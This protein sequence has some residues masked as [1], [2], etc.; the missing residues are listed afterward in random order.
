VRGLAEA[1]TPEAVA[2]IEALKTDRDREVRATAVKGIAARTSD[3][4]ERAAW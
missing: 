1:K 2:A 3:G 4:T